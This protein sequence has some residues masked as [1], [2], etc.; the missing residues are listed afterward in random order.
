MS[1]HGL[2]S[3]LLAR[4]CFH[5]KLRLLFQAHRIFVRIQFLA[6]A[7]QRSLFSCLLSCLLSATRSLLKCHKTSGHFIKESRN[8][9]PSESLTLL[10]CSHP[11]ESY[12]L[13]IISPLIISKSTLFSPSKSFS[14]PHNIS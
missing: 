6:F 8:L 4:V 5:L 9:S 10:K 11:N 12:L 1:P 7:R 14:L 2:Q 13:R 3:Q